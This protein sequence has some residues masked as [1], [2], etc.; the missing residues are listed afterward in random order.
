MPETELLLQVKDLKKHFPIRKGVFK[1][2]V[3]HV[4]AVDGV[5][6]SLN[7]GETLGVV[8]ESGCGKTTVGRMIMGAYRPTAGSIWF[9]PPN[10]KSPVDV[11]TISSSD[12]RELRTDLQMVFQDPFASLNPRMTIRDIIA[13]PLVVNKVA[14]FCQT[15]YWVHVGRL[16]I[17]VDGYNRF[18]SFGYSFFYEG[19]VDIIRTFI[20]I[21]ENGFCASKAYGQC[22]SD[23]RIYGDNDLVSLPDAQR[24]Q[25]KLQG[26]RA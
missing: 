19:N 10:G 9:N 22:G 15:H 16:A 20:Y 17:E 5:T 23:K 1:K 18:R 25:C 6:F 4:K 26:I 11:A 7:R 24:F 14:L 3:A 8:G 2:V 12:M 13:E 21:D